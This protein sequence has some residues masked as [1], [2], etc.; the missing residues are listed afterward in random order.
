MADLLLTNG[1]I[2]TCRHRGPK[3]GAAM[4]DL[5]VIEQGYVAVNG[6]EIA[7]VGA[8]DGQEYAAGAR[9]IDVAGKTVLPGLVDPHT[10]AVHAGSRENEVEMK[11]R[12]VPY[13]EILRRGGGILSTVA[14]T[15]AASPEQLRDKLTKSLDRMLLWGTT[16]VEVKS[17]YGL[18]FTDEVKCL[19]LLRDMKHPLDIVST[20]MGAHAIPTEYKDNRAGYIEMMLKEVI[21]YVAVNNLAEFI[22]CFCEHGVFSVA[23][24]RRI[25]RAGREHGLRIKLHADE[26]EPMGGGELAAELGAVSAEHLV[27]VSPAGIAAMGEAGTIP[28]L[29]PGT[30]FYLRLGRYAPARQ[31]IEAGLPVALATDYNPGTCPTESLQSVM[32][33]ASMGMGLTPAEVIS[34]ITINAAWAIGRGERVGSLEP[35]KQADIVVMDAPNENYIVY[36][37]GINHVDAVIKQGRIVVS[38]GRLCC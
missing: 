34:G 17:G 11:L 30:S 25:L 1:R 23:E 33:F 3:K 24:S 12:G 38:A 22:D 9:V 26:I 32:V 21:P 6:D 31:M 2:V 29:L 28:V 13:L 15:R 27:A 8:G 36:H 14:A 20:Y 4:S 35:G 7:A 37:F 19:A 10:H 16:T 5:G 18:N